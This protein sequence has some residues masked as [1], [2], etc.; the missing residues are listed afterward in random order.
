MKRGPIAIDRT[1]ATPAAMRTRITTRLHESV[2]HDL[3]PD[4]ARALHEDRV[5]GLHD[6]CARARRPR[7]PSRPTRRARSRARARRRRRR[8]RPPRS[9]RRSRRGNRGAS[10]P[11][12]AISPSTATV[13][14][15]SARSRRCA[16]AARI[17]TGFAF[18]AS[19]I[20]RPPPG[21]AVSCERQRE[22]ST[23]T[24]SRGGSRPSASSRRQRSGGV[25]GLMPSREPEDDV[26]PVPRRACARHSPSTSGAPK[27]RT[28]SPSGTNGSSSGACSG[29]DRDGARLVLFEQL[30][31]RARDV[32]DAAE[33]LE[34]DGRDRRDDPDMRP[35]DLGEVADL[36]R[37][38]HRHLGDDDFGVGLDPAE[39]QRQADL[40][41]EAV[42][43][44]DRAPVRAHSAARMSF[45]DVFPTVPV[46]ATT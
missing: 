31:L 24:G 6:A 5:A 14:R 26:A 44:R 35:R 46:I 1:S 27:R 37:A 34:M 11:S 28:S 29:S 15:P 9:P 40:V 13:R 16:S 12:S 7:P 38:A 21:S 42:L 23:S 4:R 36:A 32:L 8:R 22:K 18:Q 43:G 41:V 25:R 3:E 39:R 2:R 17:A 19:L 45:V 30:G 33:Q 10:P 20:S